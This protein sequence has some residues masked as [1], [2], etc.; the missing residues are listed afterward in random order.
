LAIAVAYLSQAA[1]AQ[2]QGGSQLVPQLLADGYEI[3]STA[4]FGV[5][6]V[7]LQK[8]TSAYICQTPDLTMGGMKNS[9]GVANTIRT[10]PCLPLQ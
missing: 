6:F 10:T 4:F 1:H 5:L 8:Q 2:T 7:V 9:V 3:K